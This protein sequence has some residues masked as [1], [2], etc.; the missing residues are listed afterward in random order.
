MS[1]SSSF[2]LA[3]SLPIES[4]INEKYIAALTPNSVSWRKRPTLNYSNNDL[5][6]QNRY[7]NIRLHVSDKGIIEQTKIIYSSGLKSLDK[8]IEKTFLRAS[9]RPFIKDSIATPFIVEQPLELLLNSDFSSSRKYQCIYYLNSK[10][11]NAK[12]QQAPTSFTYTTQPQIPLEQLEVSKLNLN[13]T[14]QFKLS[15]INK[16]SNVI[17]TQSSGVPSIDEKLKN[18]ILNAKIKAPRK[19]YQLFKLTFEDEVYLNQK[20]CL[21]AK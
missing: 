2:C 15:L 5:D 13:A 10:T 12:T 20:N 16:V 21:K 1:F 9:F 17:I 14:V 11:Y 18:S 3:D 19:F 6:G 4:N 8:K 7:I